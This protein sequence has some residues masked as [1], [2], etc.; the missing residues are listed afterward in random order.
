M[1]LSPPTAPS[2]ERDFHDGLRALLA[3]RPREAT[4]PLA[5]ACALP[6]GSQP[7]VCYWAAVARQRTG[8]HAGARTAFAELASRWPGS[9]HIGE[10]NIAL[11]WL[12][13]ESGD[14]AGARIR[15]AAAAQDPMPDVRSEALRGLAAS[16]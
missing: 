14:R 5:H 7:D 10:T 8:D 16:Q 15:F 4:A 11:G 1:A 13:L 12:L 9:T 6:A 2:A 3:G